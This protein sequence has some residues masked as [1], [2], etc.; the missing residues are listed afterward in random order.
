MTAVGWASFF[1][2]ALAK[3]ALERI[4]VAIVDM[5]CVIGVHG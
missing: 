4:D 2:H 1:P 3:A 5:S